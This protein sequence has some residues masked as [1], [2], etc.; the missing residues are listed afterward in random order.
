MRPAPSPLPPAAACCGPPL[1]AAPHG[2]RNVPAGGWC[3]MAVV[4]EP[5]EPAEPTGTASRPDPAARSRPATVAP[6]SAPAEP[7]PGVSVEVRVAAVVTA[8]LAALGLPVA[9]LW[10]VVAPHAVY[11]IGRGG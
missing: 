6:S 11:R 3:W 2:W 10:Y 5:A 7:G 8:A 1:P 9:G 4:S